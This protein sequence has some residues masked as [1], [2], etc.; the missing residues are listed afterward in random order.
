MA[1]PY[2]LLR[3]ASGKPLLAW[4]SDELVVAA[5]R[6]GYRKVV[7]TCAGCMHPSF[8]PPNVTIERGCGY[9]DRGTAEA[10]ALAKAKL[11]QCAPGIAQ[12]VAAGIPTLIT[13]AAGQNRSALMT[14]RVLNLVTG[15]S[16]A[17]IVTRM[18]AMRPRTSSDDG[19]FSNGVFR[20]LAQSW[21]AGSPIGLPPS[22]S[23]MGT[24]TKVIIAG[25]VGLG[26]WLAWRL[27]SGRA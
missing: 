4:G 17:S 27:I 7:L 24:G 14:A 12:G 23:S 15:E 16:G 3:D 9:A 1:G 26:A 11:A 5:P 2:I 21:P 8:N 13:C 22:V 18:M 6:L 20:R 19:A 10:I 25:T